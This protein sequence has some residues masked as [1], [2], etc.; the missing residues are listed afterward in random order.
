M[1]DHRRKSVGETDPGAPD[2]PGGRGQTRGASPAK[3]AEDRGRVVPPTPEEEVHAG[4]QSSGHQE[5]ACLELGGR[6]W[7]HGVRRGGPAN[8]EGGGPAPPAVGGPLA[9]GNPS[10]S[11]QG[12]LSVLAPLPPGGTRGS[13]GVTDL[14][15]IEAIG[16]DGPRHPEGADLSR[17]EVVAE[18]DADRPARGEPRTTDS[19][20]A[21]NV[22]GNATAGN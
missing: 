10:G 17:A 4:I 18:G 2:F 6:A 9:L 1:D 11:Q 19:L 13:L 8:D 15:R 12:R 21:G 5:P 3:L 20:A 22:S 14:R 16:G 7:V